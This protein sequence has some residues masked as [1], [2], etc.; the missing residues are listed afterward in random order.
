MLDFRHL[1]FLTLCQQQ[2]FTR[3][4]ELLHMTQ[5]AVSQHIKALETLY[6]VKLF[7]YK[8]KKMT[9]TPEGQK[10]YEMVKR[11]HA[12]C[13]YAAERMG[14]ETVSVVRFGATLTIGEFD[15]PARLSRL[16][17][18]AP[19]MRFEMA[20]DNT[21]VLLSRIDAG[22]LAFAFLEG[23]FDKGKYGYRVF[24]EEPFIAVCAPDAPFASGTH[25]FVDLFDATLILREG[26]S[27]TREILERELINRNAAVDSFQNVLEIGGMN[28]IKSLVR[29][30]VGLSFMY[31]TAAREWIEEGKL[32]KIQLV[33]FQLMRTFHFI[34]LKDSVHE[35]QYLNW[36]EKMKG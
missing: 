3:T 7:I 1:T 19:K 2:H 30:G 4:A 5:P 26:G 13:V 10:L 32:C 20:V 6:G 17:K 36:L 25:R 11:I 14:E 8:N 27:G 35:T 34:Y 9:L 28:A 18:D 22:A 31:E 16:I 23:Y 29:E 15:L 33:D 12:D 24:K 21:Q